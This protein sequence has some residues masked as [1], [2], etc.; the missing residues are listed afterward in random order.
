MS[1]S[2]NYIL[3][4]KCLG[5]VRIIFSWNKLIFFFSKGTFSWAIS[6]FYKILYF[7]YFGQ[8]HTCSHGEI[9][10]SISD[11]LSQLNSF[12]T[13]CLF[14]FISMSLS[15]L[16]AATAQ[17]YFWNGRIMFLKYAYM[18]SNIFF[19]FPVFVIWACLFV[20]PSAQLVWQ[21]YPHPLACQSTQRP[22]QT[23]ECRGH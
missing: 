15:V 5:S 9:G 10:R 18:L 4:F 3:L 23:P 2:G 21:L 16:H 11:F 6:W 17:S 13:T 1:G 7:F 12:S 22:N 14:C 8:L 20:K 19:V